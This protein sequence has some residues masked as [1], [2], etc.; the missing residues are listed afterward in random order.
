MIMKKI[1]IT[2]SCLVLAFV[3]LPK[4]LL[5]QPGEGI[6]WGNWKLHP[7]AGVQEQFDSNIFLDPV[8]EKKDWITSFSGG[9][10]GEGIIAGDTSVSAGY[11]LL[12]NMFANFTKQS[13]LNQYANAAISHDFTNFTLDVDDEFQHVFDRPDTET[14]QRVLWDLNNLGAKLSAEYN[15]FGWSA[16]YR[17]IMYNY[18]TDGWQGESRWENDV[19]LDFSYRIYTKTY[20]FTEFNYGNI[21]YVKKVN[22]DANFFQGLVG[23]RGK[24]TQKLTG[25]VKAGWQYRAYVRQTQKDYDSPVTMAGLLEQFTDRDT[26][27]IDWA[28]IPYE[29]LYSGTNFYVDNSIAL[30]YRHKFTDKL[31]GDL[32]GLYRLSQYPTSTSVGGTWKKRYDNTWSV[33]GGMEYDIQ[34]WLVFN[35]RY[36]FIQRKS[37]FGAF[38]YN[39]NLAT[40]SVKARY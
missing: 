22:S 16:E 4:C 37:N 7:F 12:Y 36:D 5:A 9:F 27:N 6:K 8:G 15:R 18:E 3:I 30:K 1:S 31:A 38:D 11:W 13:A 10:E 20:V 34:K 19:N 24:L 33:G 21:D 32:G 14:T 2:I 40:V 39:D 17:D 25:T 28:R 29:S 23:V 26:L 35:T